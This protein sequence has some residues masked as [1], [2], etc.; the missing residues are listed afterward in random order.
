MEAHWGDLPKD[1]II[2]ILQFDYK[3]R[4]KKRRKLLDRHLKIKFF[5]TPRINIELIKPSNDFN[6]GWLDMN[7]HTPH[8]KIQFCRDV[9]A[10]TLKKE[11][12]M[13]VADKNKWGTYVW[14]KKDVDKQLAR[15]K[16][17]K[18]YELSWSVDMS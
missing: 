4:S 5:Q 9:F 1:I 7:I 2:T 13:W 17:F 15:K 3:N 10:T 11:K 16:P 8:Q 14:N 12:H 18:P 6:R